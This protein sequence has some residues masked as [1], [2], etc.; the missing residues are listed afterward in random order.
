MTVYVNL[1]NGLFY[2]DRTGP[3]AAPSTVTFSVAGTAVLNTHYTPEGHSTFTNSQ[4]TI[5]IQP[6]FSRA[7]LAINPTDENIFGTKTV[8][9]EITAVDIGA[10]ENPG[11]LTFQLIRPDI[12]PLVDVCGSFNTFSNRFFYS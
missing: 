12:S 2:F 5:I 10:I 9:I 8:I 11:P 1:Q 3:T 6:G 4:G 7:T